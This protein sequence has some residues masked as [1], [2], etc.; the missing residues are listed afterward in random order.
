MET[1]QREEIASRMTELYVGIDIGGTKCAACLGDGDGRLLASV[2][3][4]TQKGAPGWQGT[5]DQLREEARRLVVA[6]GGTEVKGIGVSC[7][8]PMD[9][10]RGLIQEPA[11][12]PGWR[13]VPIVDLLCDEFS[14]ENVWLENDANAGALAEYTFG[15]SKRARSRHLVF[16][17]FGTGLGAGMILDGRPYRG[18]SGYAGEVGHVRVE[19]YGPA[20][21]GKPG[22]FEGFC[23]GGGI[24]QLANVER[25]A[26]FQETVLPDDGIDAR[27]VARGADDGDELCRRILEVSGEYLG[28]GVAILLDV[29]NPDTVVIGSIFAR[30][31][32]HLRPA[33][34]RSL[35]KEARPETLAACDVIAATLGENIG[36]YAA[37]AIAYERRGLLDRIRGQ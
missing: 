5:V 28:R 32:S 12:L 7:G 14:T 16:L 17:T 27:D 8:S 29:L 1:A 11:N 20:G 24:A 18:A 15:A 34:E 35:R 30:A 6:Q 23:S 10:E 2:R 13:D 19:R 3:I 31:E 37:L 33:M 4:R 21:C 25:R 9:T 22:S 36:N 26:W